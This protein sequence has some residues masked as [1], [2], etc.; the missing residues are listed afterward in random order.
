MK[1]KMR[2]RFWAGA[3]ALL[4]LLAGMSVGKTVWAAEKKVVKVSLGS[5]HSAAIDSEGGL[6]IWGSNVYGE[7]GNGE[8][9]NNLCES[10]PVKLM[11]GV[12]EVSLGGTQDTHSAAVTKDGSLYMW[13]SNDFGQLGDGT[14]TESLKP[15]KVM[16][17]VSRVV[18]GE[19]KTA[20]IKKDGT[21]WVWG[22]NGNNDL[23]TGSGRENATPVKLLDDVVQVDFGCSHGAALKRDGSLWMWGHS[24]GG[25][26]AGVQGHQ[27]EKVMD[28][29]K[30][31]SLG[32]KHSGALKTDGSLWMWG[33]NDWGQLGDDKSE[34]VVTEPK[35]IMDGVAQFSL[36]QLA[37]GIVKKDGSL[38]MCGYNTYIG[39]SSH[40]PKKMADGAVLVELG[41]TH[42]AMI[43]KD[44]SLWTWGG[45]WRG[46]LGDGE[47]NLAYGHDVEEPTKITVGEAA[48]PADPNPGP[49]QTIGG[50]STGNTLPRKNSNFTVQNM[51][52]K[53]TK[54]DAKNGTVT[55]VQ[56]D[57]KKTSVTIPATVKKNGY[58]F[59]VTQISGKAFYKYTKL[60]KVTFG[61]NITSIG[62]KAFQGCTALKT[63][64][65]DKNLA[66][67]GDYAFSGC[68]KL[69]KLVIPA[70]VKTVGKE[71]FSKCGS[72]K[73]IQVKST[74]LKK[75]GK[76][77]LSGIHKKATIK[78]PS[79]KLKAYRK[80]LKKKGQASTVKIVKG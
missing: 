15:K 59:K 21:L 36:G 10:A 50:G 71:A 1:A 49:G 37:T 26:L 74:V 69:A 30:Q 54:S 34:R 76:K 55:L 39:F 29:V 32:H 56:G 11:D 67:I 51:K 45:G 75:V 70:K 5:T 73:T 7:L 27:P 60:K 43:K 24:D 25:V 9:G 31:I 12:S 65:L 64:S 80:L 4:L 22:Y 38:W 44:G 72:L 16:D 35:K 6:W 33:E 41:G 52:Y 78:V 42:N 3:T 40:V 79:K 66:T 18:L 48:K 46:Q 58:T 62:S 47:K 28:G 14:T 2:K 61:K 68:K 20:A 19:R 53:V 13:G 17:G 8:R 23:G 63:V 77:A 57:K